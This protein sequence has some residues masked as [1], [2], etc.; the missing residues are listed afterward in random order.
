MEFDVVSQIGDEVFVTYAITVK[1]WDSPDAANSLFLR[2]TDDFLKEKV[3]ARVD[4]LK[5]GND[6]SHAEF[7][8]AN[9]M[10]RS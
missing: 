2:L 5:M 9:S 3:Q 4:A 8:Q 7:Y 6:N 1:P 10:A